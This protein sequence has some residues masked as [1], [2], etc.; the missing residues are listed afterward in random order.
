MTEATGVTRRIV[1]PPDLNHLA[2]LGRQDE[3]L[4]TLE[5]QHDV[6]IT[7]RGHDITL[8]GEERQVVEAERVLRELVKHQREMGV[9]KTVLLPGFAEGVE[10]TLKGKDIKLNYTI[11]FQ[12]F[13]DCRQGAYNADAGVDNVRKMLD[14]PRYLGMIGPFNSAVAKAEIPIAAPKPV[15]V[16]AGEGLA[17]LV[18]KRVRI[19][20]PGRDR[21]G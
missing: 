14:D 6:R 16:V 4:R 5:A 20:R 8:R 9:S 7:A 13:D 3:H 1:L 19:A 2:L 10:G 12:G 21:C 11:Q 18:G 17:G 15:S